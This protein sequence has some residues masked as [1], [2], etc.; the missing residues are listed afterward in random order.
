VVPRPPVVS[1]LSPLED[2]EQQVGP[3]RR[4]VRKVFGRE[5]AHG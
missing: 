3:F 5:R 4:R 2:A 1:G